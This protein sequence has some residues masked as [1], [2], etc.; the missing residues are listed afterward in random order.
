ML[1]IPSDVNNIP[2]LPF[3]EGITQSNMSTPIEIHS[4]RF[5][6]VPTPI[7]Y[8][9]FSEGSMEQTKSVILYNSS[10]GSPTDSP[11]I[12]FP[13][14]LYEAIVSADS[15]LKSLYVLP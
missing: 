11:P 14:E 1:I 2:C 13:R 9:G 7:K 3:R 15:V 6:G 8:L 5:T 4:N 10:S 12:A